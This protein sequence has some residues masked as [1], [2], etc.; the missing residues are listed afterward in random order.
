MR[1]LPSGPEHFD[2][3]ASNP[4]VPMEIAVIAAVLQ[5]YEIGEQLTL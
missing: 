1:D 2:G 5:R 3:V 4:N